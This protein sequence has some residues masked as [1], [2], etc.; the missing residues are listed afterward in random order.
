[1]ADHTSFSG[2]VSTTV[3]LALLESLRDVD[4]PADPEALAESALPLNLQRRLG[5]S[6][7]VVQQ[8][9]RYESRPG[10]VPAAEVASLFELI[11]RRPDA[12]RIFIE[13][14]QRIARS[15]LDGRRAPARMGLRVLPKAMRER[16]ALRRARRIVRQVAPEAR[17]VLRRRDHALTVEH[18]LPALATPGGVG[19]ALLDGAIQYVIDAYR[20]GELRVAHQRCEGRQDPRCEW[21]LERRHDGAGNGAGP[22]ASPGAVPPEQA[23]GGRL[24]ARPR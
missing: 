15:E 18:G 8:I 13:A 7:V 22:D 16:Q 6:P 24:P 1:M 20:A 2:R 11:G 21:A 9:R 10:D 14:G 23:A 17:V 3:A 4:T 19:C 12:P 5:L